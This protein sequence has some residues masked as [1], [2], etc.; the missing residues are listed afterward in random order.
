[1]SIGTIVFALIQ[2]LLLYAWREPKRRGSLKPWAAWALPAAFLIA[3]I[4]YS[5][6]PPY[7]FGN[8]RATA[9]LK[10]DGNKVTLRY[11]VIG[12]DNRAKTEEKQ[13]LTLIG[14]TDKFSFFY[15]NTTTRP[16]VVPISN[17]ESIEYGEVSDIAQ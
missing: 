17:I 13:Q 10:G 1:M 8:Y 14:T 15:N 11:K 12:P 7:Y 6:A 16:L 9:I 2:I 4:A 5:F 3:L